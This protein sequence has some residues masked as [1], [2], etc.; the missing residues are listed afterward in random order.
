[1]FTT[2]LSTKMSFIYTFPIFIHFISL[3]WITQLA[4]TL[5]IILNKSRDNGHPCAISNVRRKLFSIL[6][7]S[8]KFVSLF[9]A[10]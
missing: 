7:V 8:M 9:D 5:S 10:L 4:R 3:S 1:M 6:P 2:I